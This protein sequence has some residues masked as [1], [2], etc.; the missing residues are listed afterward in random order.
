MK[1]EAYMS[2]IDH[3]IRNAWL[4]YLYLDTLNFRAVAWPLYVKPTSSNFFVQRTTAHQLQSAARDEL[5]KTSAIIDPHELYH[6]TEAA[7]KA[8]ATLLGSDDYFFG[9]EQ[10]GLFDASLF[11]YT[12]L[13]LDEQIEWKSTSLTN[14]LS[15]HDNL[16]QHRSR[17]LKYFDT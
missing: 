7:F 1:E 11:A 14:A 13:L 8:L 16:V 4:Y 5:L 12:H 10:P 2:L 3:V 15:K 17:L 9:S 6:R